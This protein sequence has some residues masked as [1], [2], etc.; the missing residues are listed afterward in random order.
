MYKLDSDKLLD[1][2]N[3]GSV[4][5]RVVSFARQSDYIVGLIA[6]PAPFFTRFVLGEDDIYRLTVFEINK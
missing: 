1:V 6:T 5:G 2:W 3:S 4:S